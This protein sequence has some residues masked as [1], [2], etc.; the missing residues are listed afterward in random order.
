MVQYTPEECAAAARQIS[1]PEA[2]ELRR[3]AAELARIEKQRIDLLDQR[4]DLARALFAQD[5]S[6]QALAGLM[7]LTPRGV[8]AVR[9]RK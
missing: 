1:T 4:A 5:V 3:V 6:R 7:G 2:D 9:N 8:D